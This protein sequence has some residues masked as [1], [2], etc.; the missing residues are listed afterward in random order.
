M[1]SREFIEK[2]LRSLA[3]KFDEAKIRYEYRES[4]QSHIIEVVPLNF[5]EKNESYM[6]EEDRIEDEFEELF[7]TENIIFISEE[8]LTEINKPDYE[9]GYDD[10]IFEYENLSIKFEFF[11][12]S[13]EVEPVDVDNLALAA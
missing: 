12:F 2:N 9:L 1:K 8:S 6:E 5:Y 10:L 4:T 7:P 13:E 11:G 3:L